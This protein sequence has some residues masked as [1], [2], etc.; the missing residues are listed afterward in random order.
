MST[1]NTPMN[2]FAQERPPR[3]RRIVQWF[4]KGARLGMAA[5]LLATLSAC[6][7]LPR[8]ANDP[9]TM[10]FDPVEMTE[11]PIDVVTLDNGIKLYM[12]PDRELPLIRIRAQIHTGRLYLD[13]DERITAA[14]AL[15]LMRSGGVGDI[16]PD[17]L[18]EALTFDD[19]HMGASISL[20]SAGASLNTLTRTFPQALGYFADM[21][22]RPRF[23][24]ARLETKKD[25]ALEALRRKNDNPGQIARR[26][27]AT[28]LYGADHP[29]GHQTTEDEI[30]A[31]T[32]D[33]LVAF[34]RHHIRPDNI[35]FGITGDFDR[36]EMIAAIKGAFGD[37]R[38]APESLKK[39]VM[40]STRELKR[41]AF[42]HRDVTQVTVRMGHLSIM[43]RNPDYYALNLANNILGGGSFRSR[44]FNEVRTR[45]GLAYAV[46]SGLSPGFIDRGTFLMGVKS[47]PD[48]VAEAI[49]VML[50]ELERLRTEPVSNDELAAAKEAFLNAFV[51]KSVTANQVLGRRMVLD[52]YGF[53]EDELE[54]LKTQTMAVTP[55]DILRVAHRYLSPDRMLLFAVGNR[56]DLIPALSEFGDPVEIPLED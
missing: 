9:T 25:G 38:V 5:T 17:K 55:A 49:R 12:L 23:D 52:Y 47:R 4:G 34:H 18:D 53:P 20:T 43:R 32:R 16:E 19:I 29:S 31:V 30:R 8:A 11:P 41:V 37:W 3:H 40:I 6:A 42:S 27:F 28:L 39:P 15:P 35:A 14:M 44:L 1:S 21:L 51:F 54:R 36:D 13:P 7:G 2:C 33:K 10:H 48:Q 24:A 56:D 50:S 45:R 22:R 26:E 46:G